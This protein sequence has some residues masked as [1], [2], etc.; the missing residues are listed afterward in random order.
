MKAATHRI[1]YSGKDVF[2]G[3]DVHKKTYSVVARA[4]K[5]V[6]KKWTT[7]ASPQRFTEQLL[8]YFEGAI[9]HTA[10]EASFSAFVLHRELARQGID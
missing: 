4:D 10:Y 5:E 9:I 1:S 2:V 3:I 8:N 7:V 6:I